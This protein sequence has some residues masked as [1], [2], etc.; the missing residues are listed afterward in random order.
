MIEN[1]RRWLCDDRSKQYC[2]R[3]YEAASPRGPVKE[4]EMEQKWRVIRS[5]TLLH[6]G[7]I[8]EPII[9]SRQPG[10]KSARITYCLIRTGFT[11]WQLQQ[12]VPSS[13]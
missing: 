2:E 12:P 9:A 1:Y 10:A 6:G 3:N 8:C 11:L 4:V 5:E 7:F 13:W